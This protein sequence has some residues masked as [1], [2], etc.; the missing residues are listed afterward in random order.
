[1]EHRPTDSC[2]DRHASS[3]R[4]CWAYDQVE[5]TKLVLDP[6]EEEGGSGVVL[7]G[8]MIRE[9]VGGRKVWKSNFGTRPRGLWVWKSTWVSL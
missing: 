7:F 1:M 4:R 3:D 8:K 5:A 9:V 2:V 6:E